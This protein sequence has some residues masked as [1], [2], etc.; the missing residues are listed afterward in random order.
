M[1]V[2]VVFL[3][4]LGE[5]NFGGCEK[6]KLGD[7][8]WLFANIGASKKLIRQFFLIKKCVDKYERV[9]GNSPKCKNIPVDDTMICIFIF[10]IFS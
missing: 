3:F 7:G 8:T 1:N 5:T 2:D 4:F 6:K 9:V 10:K